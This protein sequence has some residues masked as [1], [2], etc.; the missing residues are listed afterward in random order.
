MSQRSLIV[1]AIVVNV[2]VA[3]VS[4]LL[5][6]WNGIGAHVAARWTA[7]FSVLIF[8]VAFAQPGLARFIASVPSYATLFHTFVAA[9]C[10][11][12]AAVL[13]VLFLDSGNHFRKSP[14]AATATIVVGFSLVIASGI[15]A[16]LRASPMYRA[17]HA[18]TAYFLF[19]IFMLAFGRH[20]FVPLRAL[21]VLLVVALVLRIT[22]VLQGARSTAVGA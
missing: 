15:T 9:H 4:F 3:A 17:I 1:S 18:F 10:V 7:R 22:G 11:H 2:V 13:I 5:F 19:A 14:G 8:I 6:G 12:F 16:G 21:A 20:H